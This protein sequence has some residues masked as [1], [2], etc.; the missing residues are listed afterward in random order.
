MSRLIGQ[1]LQYCSD[2]CAAH[3]ILAQTQGFSLISPR[4]F[5]ACHLLKN[6]GCFA[7][8]AT[9]QFTIFLHAETV[10]TRESYPAGRSPL[11]SSLTPALHRM[12]FDDLCRLS[13]HL[14]YMRYL[15]PC[16]ERGPSLRP[17]SAPL[18]CSSSSDPP[19]TA[20][21]GLVRCA[22]AEIASAAPSARTHTLVSVLRSGRG[23]LDGMLGPPTPLPVPTWLTEDAVLDHVTFTAPCA[24]GL[25][26]LVITDTFILPLSQDLLL[27]PGET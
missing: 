13:P 19:R 3:S 24:G 22:P 27:G 4:G 10:S 18:P 6:E 9:F 12:P 11:F 7:H 14:W 17:R 23:L 1:V 16:I 8:C 5:H 26:D 15:T 20:S 2:T 25:N 21:D